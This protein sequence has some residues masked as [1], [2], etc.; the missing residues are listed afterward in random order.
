MVSI[1]LAEEKNRVCVSAD[2]DILGMRMRVGADAPELFASSQDV[3]VEFETARLQEIDWSVR[4]RIAPL[5]GNAVPVQVQQVWSGLVPPGVRAV[6][7][8]GRN[9][10][11]LE[12]VDLGQC[13]IDLE[14]RVAS[15][16][17]DSIKRVKAS[18]YFFT[19]IL[20]T[21][22]ARS[23]HVPIHAACLAVLD[24]GEQRSVVIV[25]PSGTGKS[26][27]AFALAHSGWRLMGDDLACVTRNEGQ[28]TVWGY[29]RNCHV[30]RP[31]FALLPWL[32]DLPLQPLGI[33]DSWEFPLSSLGRMAFGPPPLPLKPAMVLVLEKPNGRGHHCELLDPIDAFATICRENVQPI[34]GCEDVDAH[35]A[36]QAISEL[37]QT[38]PCY[39]LSA[40]PKVDNL[41][42]YLSSETGV[43][44]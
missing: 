38:T 36:F 15:V 39:R 6:N 35:A 8:V 32:Q 18:R 24:G 13:D 1:G 25:A 4:L 12:L 14:R 28:L 2:Y 17:V 42:A 41:A 44:M 31:T 21:A 16:T 23:S 5:E 20:C 34:E 43:G 10:R 26:T 3:L 33:E 29:P 9:Y 30:R 40:G 19:A 37:V 22:L 27:T 11:R 7:Y